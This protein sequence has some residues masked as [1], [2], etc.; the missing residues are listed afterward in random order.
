[1]KG[2]TLSN[3]P[4]KEG[5]DCGEARGQNMPKTRQSLRLLPHEDE[6]LRTLYRDYNIPTDQFP[7]R[8]D[9]LIRLVTTWNNLTG[10]TEAAPDVLHYMVTRREKG[11]W[12]RLGRGAGNGLTRPSVQFTE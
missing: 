5:I 4:C 2:Q 12:E 3:S 8:P 1:M 9:D 11:Q 6:V 7:Q 10:R